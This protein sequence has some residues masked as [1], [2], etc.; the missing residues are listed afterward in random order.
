MVNVRELKVQYVERNLSSSAEDVEDDDDEVVVEVLFL[1]TTRGD[2]AGS[3]EDVSS[4]K[5]L[6]QDSQFTSDSD[7]GGSFTSTLPTSLLVADWVSAV[8]GLRWRMFDIV[9]LYIPIRG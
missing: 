2:V 3:E 8:A 1:A 4:S 5:F 9:F 6:S 7:G